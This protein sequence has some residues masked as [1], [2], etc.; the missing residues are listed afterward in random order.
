M[1]D[2]LT[3]K[4]ILSIEKIKTEK[5]KTKAIEAFNETFLNSVEKI[6]KIEKIKAV[7]KKNILK[8]IEEIEEIDRILLEFEQGTQIAGKKKN[9]AYKKLEKVYKKLEKAYKTLE[10]PS[11]EELDGEEFNGDTKEEV[12]S[13]IEKVGF[14][15]E[16]KDRFNGID[17]EE[18]AGFGEEI[19]EK[20]EFI[21]N[22]ISNFDIKTHTIDHFYTYIDYLV[23][24][25]RTKFKF[26][27]FER[28]TPRVDNLKK[29]F[30]YCHRDEI[31]KIISYEDELIIELIKSLENDSILSYIYKY[32]V[33]QLINNLCKD[34]YHK[35]YSNR[36][37]YI[38]IID[39]KKTELKDNLDFQNFQK[40]DVNYKIN[41]E[42][43]V[44]LSESG[45]PEKID[46]SGDS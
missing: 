1:S 21:Y 14:G 2:T 23:F 5:I 39:L 8:E 28:H 22:V 11:N 43:N 34:T 26:S 46:G 20:I 10:S 38:L 44:D 13:Y 16:S 30:A 9:E 40:I 18:F 4:L 19:E 36:N 29:A 41:Q 37:I 12:K 45:E 7:K 32:N 24:F 33:T 17:K 6:E 35:E 42:N 15:K 31:Y 25:V 3:Y 27:I